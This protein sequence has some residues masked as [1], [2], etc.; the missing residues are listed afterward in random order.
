[1]LSRKRPYCVQDAGYA[2]PDAA[3]G[4]GRLPAPERE[5]VRDGRTRSIPTC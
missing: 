3:T 1:M 2:E 5:Q 4:V